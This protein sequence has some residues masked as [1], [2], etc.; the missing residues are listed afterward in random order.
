MN[1]HRIQMLMSMDRL[2]DAE[3]EI[4]KAIAEDPNE[5]I[6]HCQLSIVLS[7]TNRANQ[8]VEAAQ[9]A[10]QLDPEYDSAYY[11]LA[12]AHLERSDYVA[13]ERAIESAKMLDPEDADYYAVEAR[14]HLDRTKYDKALDA[15]T[16]GLEI[17]P[18]NDSCRF[19]RSVAL[20]KLGRTA[21]ADEEAQLLLEQEPDDE[22]SHLARGYAKL[23]G[24]DGRAAVLHFSE[25]LRVD[26]MLD[27]ARVGLAQA[28]QLKNPILGTILRTIIFLDRQ[29]IWTILIAA[30]VLGR[31][32][33]FLRGLDEVPGAVMAGRSIGLLV[34]GGIVVLLAAPALFNLTLWCNKQ[35]RHVLSE[36]D[37]AGL[38]LSIVPLGVAFF[39]L[40]LWIFKGLLGSP[41]FALAWA[42]VAAIANDVFD[43]PNRYVRQRMFGLLAAAILVLG[44]MYFGKYFQVRPF[45]D[46]MFAELGANFEQIDKGKF[47]LD[48]EEL[49]V[50]TK[51]LRR[52]AW[53][54]INVPSL[55][56]LVGAGYRDEIS[57]WFSRRAPDDCPASSG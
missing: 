32:A 49:A 14:I 23:H 31:I 20:G 51:Q 22:G 46:A 24:G 39:C 35:T 28:L 38:K 54:W 5:S 42:C 11:A 37:L 7:R 57:E 26:P 18:K 53:R 1:I 45:R 27:A 36:E 52:L 50:Q 48:T 44:V 8:S 29:S 40:L 47:E 6:Y 33:S 30:I 17:D 3:K 4:R 55:L 15:A 2:S 43:N 13:A 10:I 16:A 56:L 12:L 9:Q 34:M 19:F 25:A 41:S 21:E